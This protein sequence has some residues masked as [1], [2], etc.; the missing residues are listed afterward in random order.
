V[1]PPEEG[2]G[3]YCNIGI[4]V[5]ITTVKMVSFLR[6]SE[7]NSELTNEK[8]DI[9]GSPDLNLNFSPAAAYSQDLELGE[10]KSWRRGRELILDL[11]GVSFLD[12]KGGRDWSGGWRRRRAG[13]AGGW[14]WSPRPPRLSCWA[15]WTV[16]CIPPTVML[17]TCGDD[18]S[19]RRRRI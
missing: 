6:F 18:R 5:Q 14:A 10:E 19:G 3:F 15:G 9:T 2:D 1:L 17:W 11:S 13:E 7:V 8:T 4:Y 16:R 12:R